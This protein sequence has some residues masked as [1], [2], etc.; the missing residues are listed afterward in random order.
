MR[1][2]WWTKKRK[3][4][5][6]D[7]GAHVWTDVPDLYKEYFQKEA[8]VESE[9]VKRF[10]KK[11][12]AVKEAPKKEDAD[13]KKEDKPKLKLLTIIDDPMKQ[14][15]LNA[16][17]KTLPEP[18]VLQRAI[19]DLDDVEIDVNTLE[20]VRRDL[21]PDP[22]QLAQLNTLRNENK[23]VPF[24]VPETYMLAIA[25]VPGYMQRLDCWLF[26]RTYEERLKK[27]MTAY[28]AFQAV[29][30]SLRTSKEFRKLLGLIL[31]A[32]NYLNGGTD[33]G[34]AEG[35]DLDVLT[36]LDAVKDV[37]GKMLSFWVVQQFFTA[38]F[39]TRQQGPNGEDPRELLFEELRPLFSAV[40]RRIEKSSDG[41]ESLAKQVSVS[42]EDYDQIAD[43]IKQECDQRYEMLRACLCQFE[44][45]AD[46][47]RT[48]L[49]PLFATASESVDELIAK[50]KQVKQEY[51]DLLKYFTM[52]QV[53]A[54]TLIKMIDDMLV[55]G[56]QITNK[57]E[58]LKKAYF[59]PQFCGNRTPTADSIMALWDLKEPELRSEESLG[60]KKPRAT[61][62]RKTENRRGIRGKTSTAT[63]GADGAKTSVRGAG[64]GKN[65]ALNV[66]SESISKDSTEQQTTSTEKKGEQDKEGPNRTGDEVEKTAHG[67]K[68]PP[69]KQAGELQGSAAGTPNKA[70]NAVVEQV[71]KSPATATQSSED[72]A[73]AAADT[74]KASSTNSPKRSQRLSVAAAEKQEN[75][76]ST[77]TPS[78]RRKTSVAASK[79]RSA[80]RGKSPKEDAEENKDPSSEKKETPI[81]AA[82]IQINI[83]QP[84]SSSSSD[85]CGVPQAAAN[86]VPAGM[87]RGSALLGASA[88]DPRTSSAHLSP[89]AS[90]AG[91]PSQTKENK[92]ASTGKDVVTNGKDATAPAASKGAVVLK[93][94]Q[95]PAAGP[96]APAA[97]TGKNDTGPPA[98]GAKAAVVAPGTKG[99]KPP[100]AAGG[101]GGKPPPPGAKPWCPPEKL[102]TGD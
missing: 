56:D 68:A 24:A 20:W 39:F 13:K 86:S 78:K 3:N 71:K 50:K 5:L 93:G 77:L 21:C 100:P 70:S 99:G 98:T 57:P 26:S 61:G 52:G 28:L 87:R 47:F 97:A 44:D 17:C 46:S 85:S 96:P 19:L 43:Q 79:L 76:D 42:I 73:A 62:A 33:R 6:P 55:P 32:G 90:S 49:A 18:T 64:I 80:S 9:F 82:Q 30:R 16:A 45:P 88:A 83:V 91:T 94:K 41:V 67:D 51:E 35:V 34:Q 89:S 58:K 95:A 31:C 7:D 81:E 29:M 84:P 53:K 36:K 10:G 48:V 101:K 59:V 72:K 69:E 4:Q 40:R 15:G 102:S 74:S 23:G 38:P 60:Q 27:C 65:S 25:H 1:A 22:G 37:E 75:H 14:G 63:G 92:L 54:A 12:A 11:K 2:L 8:E 66:G